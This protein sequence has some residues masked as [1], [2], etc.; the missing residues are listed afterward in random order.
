LDISDIYLLYFSSHQLPEFTSNALITPN[1][2][3]DIACT[4]LSRR[5]FNQRLSQ[6]PF[7]GFSM[8]NAYR[9]LH[10]PQA[11]PKT[12]TPPVAPLP[13]VIQTKAPAQAYTPPQSTNLHAASIKVRIVQRH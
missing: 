9:S 8:P 10:S 1:C 12:S 7:A 2:S 6:V 11:V 5:K 4:S 3:E 13:V